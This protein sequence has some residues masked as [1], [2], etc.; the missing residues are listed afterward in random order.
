MICDDRTTALK[1]ASDEA[2]KDAG[3]CRIS[4]R[5][6][7][8]SHMR[9]RRVAVAVL[10]ALGLVT[11]ASAA[12]PKDAIVIGLVAEPVTMDPPQ[13][14]DL[15][16]ARVTK[17]IFE[18]LVGQEL[19]SY[20]L[21]PGLAQSW[22]ISKDGLT[23]TFKLRGNVTFHD[24]TPFNAEAVK[25]VFERQLNDKG[26]YY[27]TGTYPYVKGFLGNVAGVEVLDASTVQIKLKAPLTPFLQY[28]AH[29][30][31]F[32][33]SPE[34]LKKWGKDVV[35]HPVGTGPFK[36]ETWEPGV[37][38]VLARNDAYWGGAPKIR[39]AIYVPIVEAQARLVALKT[40][41]IDLTMDVPPDALDDLRRDPNIVVAESNSSAVWY[42]TL[43][44]RHPIL[45][46]RRVRQA[47]NHAVNKD[48]IIRDILRGTAIVS[49]GPMSPVYGAFYE[50][51]TARYPHDLEKARA[52]LKEAGYASGFDVTFLV[53]ESGSGMQSPVEMATVIQAN[54]AQ[55][56]VRARIQ[57]M[58]WG[59]Y[60]RKYLEQPDMAEMSWNPSIGDPDHMMYML[61]SSDRFPPAFNAGYYQNDRVDDLLRR[62]RT[63][64][65]EK[66]R[67]PLY[68]EAQRLVV[69]DAPWIFVDH[70]KQVIVHRKRVQGF[71]LHPN[72][73]L[74]LT[75]VS[76]Q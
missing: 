34:S 55:I 7:G 2:M 14:T 51:N 9:T 68:K 50:E 23:Y 36:L 73:D 26:P 48:A 45:K 49:R 41:D 17:R 18:G 70:G 1:W 15:N 76:L 11:A 62:G 6:G 5:S 53:P 28:L 74:V 71:K 40:G 69:E 66:A 24:G 31:L 16:S 13:I 38:V 22:D 54:L 33:F 42:V 56:G 37:K 19:G 3:W 35:K 47:L 46:D 39:Q 44:T 20:K 21:V 12:P 67:V 65:D 8:P 4:R 60:L 64:I 63:T 10:V 61:L 57:T 72:F 43:N 30:S 58:E 52:L 59:A 29:Q 75:P 25:F 27:A 32:M